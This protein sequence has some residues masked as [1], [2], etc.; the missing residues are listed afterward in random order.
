ME[1][2]NLKQEKQC[3]I[4]D[5]SCSL[6][7]YFIAEELIEGQLVRIKKLSSCMS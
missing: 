2:D 3:A 1:N 4:H 7:G 5:V 6:L